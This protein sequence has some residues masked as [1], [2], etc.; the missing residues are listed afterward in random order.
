MLHTVYSICTLTKSYSYAM[1][2][3]RLITLSGGT[4]LHKKSPE[5]GLNRTL[6]DFINL[7]STSAQGFKFFLLL[8]NNSTSYSNQ[9][10]RVPI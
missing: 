10:L 8:F 6:I 7:Q 1:L 9:A 2:K 5:N 4:N 3:H